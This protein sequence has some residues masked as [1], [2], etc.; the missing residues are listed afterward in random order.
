M[1]RN[2]SL[3]KSSETVREARYPAYDTIR[4]RVEI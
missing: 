3:L 4:I 2:V 1:R